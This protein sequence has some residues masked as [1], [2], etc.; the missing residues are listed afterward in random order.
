MYIMAF[1]PKSVMTLT[2]YVCRDYKM[3]I[4]LCINLDGTNRI[5]RIKQSTTH[6]TITHFLLNTLYF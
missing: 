5:K 4:R 3:T 1:Y 6:T 2:D